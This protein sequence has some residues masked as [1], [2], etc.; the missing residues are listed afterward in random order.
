MPIEPVL[1][2]S[3]D[4]GKTI[5]ALCHFANCVGDFAQP[6]GNLT[7]KLFRSRVFL[8]RPA[9]AVALHWRQQLYTLC[10]GFQPLINVHD[11]ILALF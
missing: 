2:H 10:Q 9:F 3:G 5:D 6:Q 8:F 1:V 4:A 7:E 11:P